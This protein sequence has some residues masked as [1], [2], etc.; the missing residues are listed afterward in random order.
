MFLRQPKE[1]PKKVA[2]PPCPYCESSETFLAQIFSA[3]AIGAL[4]DLA[5]ESCGKVSFAS[6]EQGGEIAASKEIP[7]R[8]S[9]EHCPHCEHCKETEAKG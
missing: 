4:A 2:S 7:E 6:L 5:C 9:E 1:R 8:F 3:F